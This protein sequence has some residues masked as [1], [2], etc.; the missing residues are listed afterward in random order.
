MARQASEHPT[1]FELEILKVLWKH[2]PQ[3]VREI[4]ERLADAGRDNA[5]T[6]VIT[7]LNIMV[8]KGYLDKKKDGK[9]YLFWPI[10]V[11][12][13]ISQKMLGDMVARVFNGSARN[14]VS[15]LIDGEEI[16]EAEL[17]ELRK[18][19]QSKSSGAAKMI[20]SDLSEFI[21]I[22]FH[23][24]SCWLLTM[25]LLHSL[26]QGAIFGL[27][28]FLLVRK[29][30]AMDVHQRYI[31]IF[32]ILVLIAV[33]PIANL[34]WL[35]GSAQTP[36]SVELATKQYVTEGGFSLRQL[37]L[38]PLQEL[39]APRQ[40]H[41]VVENINQST[42]VADNQRIT[43]P[44]SLQSNAAVQ[45]ATTRVSW[46]VIS[47][48]F[49][50]LCY[51]IG[52]CFMLLRLGF[53]LKTNWNVWSYSRQAAL[54]AAIPESVTVAAS[55]ASESF[56]RILSVPIALFEGHGVA[57]LVG[58]FRPTILLNAT[59]MS[60]LTPRQVEQII[61]HELAHI[62]RYDPL[63]QFIQ[64]LIESVLFFHPALWYVSHHVSA[65]REMCCDEL[66][67]KQYGHISY[68]S[69]LI[70]CV[71]Q[72]HSS[73]HQSKPNKPRPALSLGVTGAGRSQLATR[74]DA[75]LV[76]HSTSPRQLSTGSR[77][78]IP[79]AAAAIALALLIGNQSNPFAFA[80][81]TPTQKDQQQDVVVVPIW[82]WQ[83]V[84]PEQLD[85]T[86]FLFG[87]KKL[88]L[89]KSIPADMK[90]HAMVSDD[91]QRFAQWHFGD[92]SS[93]RVGVL[94]ETD[95]GTGTRLFIDSNRDRVIEDNE[96]VKAKINEG[97]TWIAD[98]DVEVSENNE[99]VHESRQIGVTPIQGGKYI[100][101]TT[102]GYA[103]GEIELAGASTTVR[104]V[105]LNGNGLPTERSDQIWFDFD[106]DGKFDLLDERRSLNNYL[107]V[108]GQRYTVR[109]DRLGQSLKLT[110]D[111]D[112]GTIR[113]LHE[114]DDK[115]ATLLT[116]DGNLRDDAGML[117]SI[118]P[119]SEPVSIPTGRYCVE[120]L[121]VEA[122][123][124]AGRIWRMTLARKSNDH[125]FEIETGKQFE[126]RL[127]ESI[128]FRVAKTSHG[129]DG[130]YRDHR[131]ELEPEVFTG[132]GLI[133][134]DFTCDEEQDVLGRDKSV[135]VQFWARGSNEAKP[136]Q[137]CQSG[138]T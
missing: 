128:Q 87:G 10:V 54:S 83:T 119:H 71:E 130:Y 79:L 121:L 29:K 21:S 80:S 32:S 9:S 65:L 25:A 30:L 62:Y 16:E 74:I 41:P 45:S 86:L 38:V 56:G 132:N 40:K 48:V 75:L 122:R 106:N 1:G 17:L 127:L 69:T 6:S 2:S 112:H 85:S 136:G 81:L 60:G 42:S 73:K 123:D 101:I 113:F 36:R 52:V 89:S 14:L 133:V 92:S 3:T 95:G 115:S 5:H 93:T 68:A 19:D 111:N 59:I 15:N 46:L 26:W 94:L 88:K 44:A 66:V 11:E 37:A 116:L 99:S 34:V 102:L 118:R 137:H 90:I 98:L 105:D 104:R 117:I 109:S 91:H 97:K 7:M 18:A 35:S 51:F 12:E 20:L 13:N 107:D 125:W 58:C 8:D 82:K 39:S 76:E 124:S 114:L 24:R 28:V 27:V 77:F 108:A 134:T 135:N 78:L 47:T 110:I 33:S 129:D 64:R 49:V 67:A 4:R 57:I 63:T 131:T 138:F 50:S 55:R 61:F 84:Q 103:Q 23:P 72:E 43:T 22:V 53:G 96:Q 120:N 100:R 126:L 31:A 70:T